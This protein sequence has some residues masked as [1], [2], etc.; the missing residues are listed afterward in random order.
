MNI[1]FG[2]SIRKLLYCLGCMLCGVPFLSYAQTHRPSIDSL[3]TLASQ[4]LE[5]NLMEAESTV[6]QAL[7]LTE[8]KPTTA[9]HAK[10]V[11]IYAEV[12]TLTKRSKL[13][14][15]Y[16]QKLQVQPIEDTAANI[17]LFLALANYFYECG[18]FDS[19]KYYYQEARQLVSPKYRV[20]ESLPYV[21]MAILYMKMGMQDEATRIYEEAKN[22]YQLKQRA[23]DD[24]WLTYGYGQIFYAQRLYDRA[25]EEL[26]KALNKFIALDSKKGIAYAELSRGNAF[27]LSY[28]EEP[29]IQSYSRALNSFMQLADSNGTAICYANL[30]RVYLDIGKPHKALDYANR[31]IKVIDKGNY[32]TLEASIRQHLG[33]I[34]GELGDINKAIE[35]VKKAL[36][37]AREMDNKI[38][39]K[40]CYKSLSEMYE[41]LKQHSV[42]YQ[43]LLAAYRIKDSIQPVE[44]NKQLAQMQARF[45]TEKKEA[46]IQLLTQQRQIDSLLMQEQSEKLRKQRLLLLMSVIVLG[47]TLTAFYFYFSRRRLM[48]RIREK[49]LVREAEENERQR[50]AKD[51]HDDFGSGLSKIKILAERITTQSQDPTNELT[52]TLQSIS[53]TAVSLIE[54]MRDLVWIMKSENSTL[55]GLVARMREYTYEYLEDLPISVQFLAPKEIPEM[56]IAKTTSRNIQMIFKEAIQ[57]V[58]KHADA[59]ELTI[60]IHPDPVFTLKIADNGKGFAS[61]QS[62]D[63]NGLKNMKQRASIIHGT[64]ELLSRPYE[65]TTI[66]LTV[67]LTTQ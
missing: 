55:E 47:A 57:N 6:L 1:A 30:S 59:T 5:K 13:A 7:K 64:C 54:N 18:D 14:K 45:E 35:N 8:E 31:V 9:A 61:D 16:L 20:D 29:A 62:Y 43:Y 2:W 46:Q 32:M 28:K 67:D 15:E 48:E 4:L 25:L 65:G 11:R 66:T 56:I 58:V 33:D 41:A 26:T 27:Y 24:A 37:I 42:S 22:E 44:F 19:S 23:R 63:G 60:I 12:L 3:N 34:Y 21:R 40:D 49:E 51:I 38:V 53:S 10:A 52:S 50:I 36:S 17:H 39:V